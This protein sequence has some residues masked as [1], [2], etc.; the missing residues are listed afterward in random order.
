MVRLEPGQ[1]WPFGAD[2]EEAPPANA[3]VAQLT[4]S[5]PGTIVADNRGAIDEALDA[6]NATV[7]GPPGGGG[8]RVGAGSPEPAV[9]VLLALAGLLVGRRRRHGER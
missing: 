9:W 3:L 1:P 2:D 5:G 8:C 7:P 4:T 6:H